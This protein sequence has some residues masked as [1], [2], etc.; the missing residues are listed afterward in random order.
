MVFLYRGELEIPNAFCWAIDA[1]CRLWVLADRREVPLL[2]NKC[3]DAIKE[4]VLEDWWG[5]VPMVKYVYANT[6]PGS[7]LRRF[8]LLL[9]ARAG[10]TALHQFDA[11]VSRHYDEDSLRDL[12]NLIW[13][14]KEGRVWSR[15]DLKELE[16]CPEYHCHGPGEADDC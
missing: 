12:C 7:A 9:A 13:G 6:A 8:I 11:K 14:M 2:M 3:I 15:Y 1:L 16:T 5:P 10:S 4:K